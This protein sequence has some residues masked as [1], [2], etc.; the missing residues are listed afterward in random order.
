[1]IHES[2]ISGSSATSGDNGQ[3]TV[4]TIPCGTQ[5]SLSSTIGGT[6][7][8]LDQSR[9]IQ[10]N[11]DGTCSSYIR[12]WADSTVETYLFGSS[13]ISSLY[14][15]VQ[16]SNPSSGL[17]DQIGFATR[18]VKTSST[19]VG[20][21]VGGAIGGIVALALIAIAIFFIVRRRKQKE[22]YGVGT[23]APAEPFI[24]PAESEPT[25]SHTPNMSDFP[26]SSAQPHAAVPPAYDSIYHEDS[27]VMPNTKT[28]PP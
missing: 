22:K 6:S 23:Y 24:Y 4:W 27:V 5:F 20:P 17:P 11:S 12:G 18:V 13:F 19:P 7:F 3:S 28:R 25:G 2:S 26:S 9:L 10:K 15:I 1:L 14:L 16:V 8:S 21:I